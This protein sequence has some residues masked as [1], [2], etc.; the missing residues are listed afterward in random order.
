MDHKN[1]IRFKK[2]AV[3]VFNTIPKQKRNGKKL[4]DLVITDSNQN[5]Y[6]KYW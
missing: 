1:V 6:Y 2:E 3:T 4:G 5:G